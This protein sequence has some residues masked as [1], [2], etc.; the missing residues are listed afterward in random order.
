MSLGRQAAQ[1]QAVSPPR[2]NPQLQM[3]NELAFASPE[4]DLVVCQ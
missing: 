3:E 4:A 2:R 1:P